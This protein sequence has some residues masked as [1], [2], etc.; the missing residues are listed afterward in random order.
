MSWSPH[1]LVAVF[2]TA[3]VAAQELRVALPGTAIP[4]PETGIAGPGTLVEANRQVLPFDAGRE[5]IERLVEA[6][7]HGFTHIAPA[8]N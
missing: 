3:P 2:A 7:H 5:V 1:I 8:G 4:T 6:G